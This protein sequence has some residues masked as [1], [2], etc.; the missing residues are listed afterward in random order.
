VAQETADPAADMVHNFGVGS[1]LERMADSVAR[2]THANG[3][4]PP[5]RSSQEIRKL[6]PKYQPQWDANLAKAYAN[7]LNAEELRSLAESGRSSPYFG[8]LKQ[9]QPAVSDDM[10]GMSKGILQDLVTEALVNA[11]RAG[12]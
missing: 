10:Q 11:S 3:S 7:H 1:N 12:P 2:A 9:V 5:G 6:L 4:L 8:K